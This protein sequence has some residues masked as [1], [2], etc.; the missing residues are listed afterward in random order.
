MSVSSATPTEEPQAETSSGFS[1]MS[2]PSDAPVDPVVND[3]DA[4]SSFSFMASENTS[5]TYHSEEPDLLSL[6]HSHSIQ[7]I[8]QDLKLNK[9]ASA[10]AVLHFIN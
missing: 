3:N 5:Q 7:T 1:F 6:D 9:V 4:P 8:P 10:K 2:S